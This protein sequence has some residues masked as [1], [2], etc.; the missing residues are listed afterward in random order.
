MVGREERSGGMT[1]G[2]MSFSLMATRIR[3]LMAEKTGTE[4]DGM[5]KLEPNLRSMMA[6]WLRKKV[7]SCAKEMVIALLSS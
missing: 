4:T 2:T 3:A 1:K 5:K 7:E 6:A